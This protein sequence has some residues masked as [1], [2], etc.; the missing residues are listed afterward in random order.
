[1]HPSPDAVAGGAVAVAVA[2]V[3]VI[4]Y[5]LLSLILYI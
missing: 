1:M 3:D 4:I 2:A 5:Y